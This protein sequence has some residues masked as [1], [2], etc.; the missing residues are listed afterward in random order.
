MFDLNLAQIF[1]TFLVLVFSL[2]VHEAAHAWA[3]DQCGD[4]TAKAMGRLTLNP[5]A[6]I[7]LIGTVVFPLMA[8]VAHVP[9]IGWA[10]PVPVNVRRL[11]NERKD[12]VKVAAAG[13]A[14]NLVL[15]VTAALVI[16]LIPSGALAAAGPGVAA[17][18]VELLGRM[19]QINVLLAIFNMLPIP[20]LDGAGVLSGLLPRRLGDVFDAVRPYGFLLL[21]G[22]ML[23][24]WLAVLITR[25]YTMVMSW[26]L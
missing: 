8:L 4:S 5:M 20:P 2:T 11:R 10:K 9:V 24:G 22:L 7:D 18:L 17:P 19:L 15:A 6:H 23:T 3:A 1:I 25:P 26:L 21:Y 14:S 16:R 13:P 12:W